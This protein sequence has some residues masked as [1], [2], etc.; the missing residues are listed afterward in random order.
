MNSLIACVKKIYH[1]TWRNYPEP[2]GME[3]WEGW[4]NSCKGQNYQLPYCP[5]GDKGDL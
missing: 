5:P 2:N 1:E 3:P 4:K